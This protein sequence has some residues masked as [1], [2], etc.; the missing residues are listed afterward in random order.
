MCY[1]LLIHLKCLTMCDWNAHAL[2]AKVTHTFTRRFPDISCSESLGE[3]RLNQ[4]V[5]AF[6][7]EMPSGKMYI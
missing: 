6:D 1:P 5:R 7:L 4:P 2:L 3:K